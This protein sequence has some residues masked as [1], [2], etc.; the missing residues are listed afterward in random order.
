MVVEVRCG[1]K[2]LCELC[3][4]PQ[5]AATV[6]AL[7]VPGSGRKRRAVLHSGQLS[8]GTRVGPVLWSGWRGHR[9]KLPDK[10]PTVLFS[11]AET[12]LCSYAVRIYLS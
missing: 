7:A 11:T 9:D 12:G 8:L 5:T 3:R 6:L 2:A 10:R 4:A 1:W